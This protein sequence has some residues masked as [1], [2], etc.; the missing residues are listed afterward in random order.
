MLITRRQAIQLAGAGCAELLTRPGRGLIPLGGINAGAG[1]GGFLPAGHWTPTRQTLAMNCVSIRPDSETGSF[2]GTVWAAYRYAYYDGANPVQYE[3]PVI[4]GPGGSEP[5][6]YQITSGPLWLRIGSAFGSTNY[7]VLYGTPTSAISTAS[8]ATVTIRIYDQALNFV[9]VTYTLAT[10]SSTSQFVFLNAATGNDANGGTFGSPCQ[11]LS[12]YMPTTAGGSTSNP[13]ASCYMF[14][15]ATSYQFPAQSGAAVTGGV[16][17]DR[18]HNPIV[19]RGIPGTGNV[20]IDASVAQVFDTGTSI[21]DAYIAGTTLDRMTITGSSATA[22][23]T[24]T[25]ELYNPSRVGFRSVDFVNPVNRTNGSLT[26]STSVFAF[27]DSSGGVPG[28]NFWHMSDCT[29]NGRSGAPSNSMLLLSW[30]SI[31]NCAV[32]SCSATGNPSGFG[33]FF[34]DSIV[35]GVFRY[36]FVNYTGGTGDAF[37]WGGQ[38]G[39]SPVV[40]GVNLDICYSRIIGGA[41]K[42]DFQ[43][44]ATSGLTASRRNTVYRTDTNETYAIGSNAP[45][46]QGPYYSD[47]DVLISRIGPLIQTSGSVSFTTS[48]TEVQVP[49]TGSPPPGSNN[50]INTST[51]ALVDSITLWKTLYSKTS[52]SRGWELG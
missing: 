14:G 5:Y 11:H 28:K 21:T 23:D 8:P 52:N 35:N 40:E 10:S 26:N 9:D 39:E 32:E 1:G 29:E 25:F 24:H 49:W 50:P 38:E 47:C 48:G 18:A 12:K 41:I 15:S 17:L 19:Y 43:G 27:N 7:G 22:N 31:A 20:L 33:V 46:G 13:G 2:G 4:M 30:F 3:W 51:L 16:G 34:K 6:V 42:F 44:G 45:T 37:M 36:G